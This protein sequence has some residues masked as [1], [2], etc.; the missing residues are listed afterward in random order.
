MGCGAFKSAGN[1]TKTSSENE[2]HKIISLEQNLDKAN[3]ENAQLRNQVSQ[4]LAQLED[5]KVQQ[6]Q[7]KQAHLLEKAHLVGSIQQNGGTV[8]FA[9]NGQCGSTPAVSS[10]SSSKGA[11]ESQDASKQSTDANGEEFTGLK[12]GFLLDKQQEKEDN[13]ELPSTPTDVIITQLSPRNGN[14]T[15]Y[16]MVTKGTSHSREEAEVCLLCREPINNDPREV[17]NL[18]NASP[19]CL[20]LL[21]RRCYLNPEIQMNDQLRKC[22]ICHKPADPELVRMAVA[23]RRGR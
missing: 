2:S 4:L 9:A 18:C 19:R 8:P 21:H 14:S 20:C 22:M 16:S 13:C 3:K 6:E 7:L 10:I 17:V 5:N 15:T 1:G 23:A 11:A 12:K